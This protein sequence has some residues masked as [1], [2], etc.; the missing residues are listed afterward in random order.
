MFQRFSS[1]LSLSQ[2]NIP[3][4]HKS[5]PTNKE[6]T[7][8]FQ[9][10]SCALQI[11][12][13]LVAITDDEEERCRRRD[14]ASEAAGV[15]LL[16]DQQHGDGDQEHHHQPA[17]HGHLLGAAAARLLPSAA[18]TVQR[19]SELTHRLWWRAILHLP[20]RVCLHF[21]SLHKQDWVNW[22]L[23]RTKF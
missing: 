10:T 5:Q 14:E 17:V 19:R 7:P 12:C 2:L 3:R 22:N 21:A 20:C 23:K 18:A 1:I 16:T 8:L 6:Q 11:S 13:H 9:Y 4:I 15:V